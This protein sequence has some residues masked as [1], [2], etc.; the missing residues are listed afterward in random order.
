M[1]K[2]RTGLESELGAVE[3]VPQPT[4]DI[5]EQVVGSI[6]DR[7]DPRDTRD[8]S[9]QES[10]ALNLASLIDTYRSL[11]RMTPEAYS[12]LAVEDMEL[13][14]RQAEDA[15]LAQAVSALAASIASMKKTKLAEQSEQS[16]KPDSGGMTFRPL[17]QDALSDFWIQMRARDASR[18]NFNSL[19]YADNRLLALQW[20]REQTDAKLGL[21][22]KGAVSSS[23]A[24]NH[25]RASFED[26]LDGAM[27]FEKP[28]EAAIGFNGITNPEDISV[29]KSSFEATVLGW[30]NELRFIQFL[31]GR[32]NDTDNSQQLPL[33]TVERLERL[34]AFAKSND[35]DA[36]Q[37]LARLLFPN[38]AITDPGKVAPVGVSKSLPAE[39]PETYQGL[40]GP[41]TPPA[42][43]QRVYGEWLGHGLTRAHIRQLDPALSQAINNWSRKNEWPADVDL[44]TKSEQTSRDIEAM[45][46]AAAE[47]QA[48][49]VVGEFTAKEAGRMHSA[50]RRRGI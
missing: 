28:Y 45:R 41:E 17:H 46:A 8:S 36:V 13:L 33:T 9:A 40:R 39:A 43:V 47:G 2:D 23:E 42:F 32:L 4:D 44:P 48:G 25:V 7:I 35:E 26:H 49:P 1:A 29:I 50:M 27:V 11:K 34:T 16:K 20:A 31:E 22:L 15:H 5:S 24:I 37:D 12:A 6:P 14:D 38:W 19:R 3:D 21:M 30:H 10:A 18:D